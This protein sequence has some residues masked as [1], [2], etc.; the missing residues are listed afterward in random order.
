MKWN[1]QIKRTPPSLV[2]GILAV[3]T[4]SYTCQINVAILLCKQILLFKTNHNKRTE[5]EPL[6]YPE[7]RT[8]FYVH[9]NSRR[10]INI[11][12]AFNNSLKH[13]SKFV[14]YLPSYIYPNMNT[15]FEISWVRSLLHSRK[16]FL[17]GN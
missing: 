4:T 10:N 2:L 8:C 16:R 1:V 9:L 15:N 12:Y 13:K 11:T 7:I 6:S 3:E 14:Q 5:A 17:K